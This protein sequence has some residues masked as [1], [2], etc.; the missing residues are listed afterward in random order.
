MRTTLKIDED[1]LKAAR[2]MAGDESVSV[3]RVVSRLARR[4]L[5]PRATT[6]RRWQLPPSVAIPRGRPAIFSLAEDLR[7][8]PGIVFVILQ[9][10]LIP[11]AIVVVVR[12]TAG[13]PPL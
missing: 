5:E 2:K 13:L 10:L 1:V 4:G 9:V 7:D 12:V 8:I 6:G 3:G 11:L